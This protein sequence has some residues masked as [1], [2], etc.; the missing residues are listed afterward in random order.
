MIKEG[1]TWSSIDKTFVVIAR[2][3]L[4]GN[5]WIHYRSIEKEPKEF[6]CFE[7]SFLQRFRPLPD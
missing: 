1:S 4:E 6:S 3:E 5:I 7:A 2:V